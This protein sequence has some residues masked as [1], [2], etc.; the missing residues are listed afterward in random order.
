MA[1]LG[2]ACPGGGERQRNLIADANQVVIVRQ[3]HRLGNLPGHGDPNFSFRC[4]QRCVGC[5]NLRSHIAAGLLV[6][7]N[8]A[9]LD[10]L[11]LDSARGNR[12][13]AS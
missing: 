11:C 9:T 13:N 6:S 10:W 12:R 4:A 3:R 8:D 2:D 1:L 5:D 7:K